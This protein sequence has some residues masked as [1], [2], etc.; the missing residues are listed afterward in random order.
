MLLEEMT[1]QVQYSLI[2]KLD[3]SHIYKHFLQVKSDD[4]LQSF[5]LAKFGY[6]YES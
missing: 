5:T 3:P 2:T 6:N 1:N 4:P